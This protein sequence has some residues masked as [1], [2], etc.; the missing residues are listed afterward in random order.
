[1]ETTD[2]SPLISNPASSVRR[3]NLAEVLENGGQENLGKDEFLKLLTVQ[4]SH[5]DPLKPMSNT[6][7]ISQMA[8]FSALEQ[9]KNMNTSV[10]GLKGEFAK[11]ANMNLI[12]KKVAFSDLQGN[13][14]TGLVEKINLKGET[15]AVIDGGS[16]SIANISSI[17]NE[18][19]LEKARSYENNLK[20]TK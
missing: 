8:E 17:V 10:E 4:L 16:V 5:Q 3:N 20:T 15:K 7:F 18:S 13:L 19:H 12:G 2:I 9:M 11:L 6:E 14:K 1:M